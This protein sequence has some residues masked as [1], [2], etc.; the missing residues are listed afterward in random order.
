MAHLSHLWFLRHS[1]DYVYGIFRPFLLVVVYKLTY[2]NVD[3]FTLELSHAVTSTFYS[4]LICSNQQSYSYSIEALEIQSLFAALYVYWYCA[5]VGISIYTR[6]VTPSLSQIWTVDG[7]VDL[8]CCCTV[9]KF[10]PLIF[11]NIRNLSRLTNLCR[12]LCYDNLLT[13]INLP[14]RTT[15]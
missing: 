13:F 7:K 10:L 9:V 8:F 2:E 5:G 6:I 15:K 14:H 12:Y 3:L 1:I 11:S 4:I